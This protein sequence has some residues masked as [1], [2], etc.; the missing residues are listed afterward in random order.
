MKVFQ[1]FQSKK[2]MVLI[3][4]LWALGLLTIFAVNIGLRVRQKIGFLSRLEKRDRVQSFAVSGVRKALAVLNT[5]FEKEEPPDPITTKI[6]FH[7]NPLQLKGIKI[8]RGTVDVSYLRYEYG[9]EEPNKVYGFIDEESKININKVDIEVL[10]ELLQILGLKEE[11]AHDLAVAIYDWRVYGESEIVGFLSDEF[12]RNLQFPY[13]EKKG[14]FETTDELLLVRGMNA[15]IYEGLKHFVTI[16]GEGQV[17]VNTASGP[18]LVALGLDQNLVAKILSV[19]RGPDSLEAT[20][21]DVVFN[22]VGNILPTLA[23]YGQ[24]SPEETEQINA[25]AEMLTTESQHFHIQST[26]QLDVSND[27]KVIACVFRANDGKII[28]WR[29]E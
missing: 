29:E 4:V 5:E 10:E 24:L 17:N 27:K 19:R 13:E 21:D 20:A 1:R 7:N 14:D 28:Y 9:Q 23:K 22:G 2:G 26:A 8:G 25:A 11:D 18:V 6:I 15:A 16:Y 12:Y 3:L